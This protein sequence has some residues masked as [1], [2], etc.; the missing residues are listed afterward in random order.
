MMNFVSS[1]PSPLA[2]R[3]GYAGLVPFV[4]LAALLWMVRAELRA[5]VVTALVGY[6]A[7]I[8]S[9]LGGVHW[10]IAG[11]LPP[12]NAALHYVWGV[13]PSLLA[14]AALA[15]PAGYALALLV[16]ILTI[17]YFVDRRSYPRVGWAA[18]LPMRLQLTVV[19][20]LSCALGAARV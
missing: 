16:L 7:V 8:A 14:W 4:L 18:W 15:M 20:V 17:C 12:Q 9:F 13:L 1:A 2:R 19:A 10:G 11:Q 5:V 3:L 6:G